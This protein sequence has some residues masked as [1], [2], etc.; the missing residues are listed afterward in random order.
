MN[1]R[2]VISTWSSGT[3]GAGIF[4]SF[5]YAGLIEIGLSPVNTMLLMLS[6]PMLEGAA[7]WILLRNPNSIPKSDSEPQFQ[8][9]PND[10]ESATGCKETKKSLSDKIRYVPSLLKYVIPLLAVYLF[11]YFINQG[12][13]SVTTKRDFHMKKKTYFFYL[14]NQ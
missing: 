7:F 8:Q 12:L 3:G 14:V 6:V 11:E 10:Q 4:G 1:H 5:L 9:S 2:N 13:V